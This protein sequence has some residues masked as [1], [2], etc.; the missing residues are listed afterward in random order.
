ME[1]PCALG[2]LPAE[3]WDYVARLLPDMDAYWLGIVCKHTAAAH[4]Y[5]HQK[6]SCLVDKERPMELADF[7]MCVVDCAYWIARKEGKMWLGKIRADYVFRKA[8]DRISVIQCS[9][10]PKKCAKLQHCRRIV[11]CRGAGGGFYPGKCKYSGVDLVPSM[12]DLPVQSCF[13]DRVLFTAAFIIGRLR[14]FS[15]SV[16]RC[17]FCERRPYL[18]DASGTKHEIASL[19]ASSA[20]CFDYAFKNPNLSCLLG[21]GVAKKKFVWVDGSITRSQ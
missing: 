12:M 13:C 8:T 5:L 15:V 3:I 9:W 2:R 17:P 6:K 21:H 4:A 10:L 16:A 20:S 7:S 19:H 14:N 11:I 18:R 1:E